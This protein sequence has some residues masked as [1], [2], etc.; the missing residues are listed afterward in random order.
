MGIMFTEKKVVRKM[1]KILT[2]LSHAWNGVV[3]VVYGLRVRE[4]D[5]KLLSYTQDEFPFQRNSRKK[6][7]RR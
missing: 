7:I 5:S 3:S 2:F 1:W 4:C 6:E